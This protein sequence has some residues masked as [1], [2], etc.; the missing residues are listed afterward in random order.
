[1]SLRRA[2]EGTDGREGGGD[3]QI[4]VVEAMMAEEEAVA[5]RSGSRFEDALEGI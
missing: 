1:M 4:R 2:V 3:G 5:T